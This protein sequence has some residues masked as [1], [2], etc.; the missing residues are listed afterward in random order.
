MINEGLAD[1]IVFGSKN[2]QNPA[3]TIFLHS[4]LTELINKLRTT[5]SASDASAILNYYKVVFQEIDTQGI[6]ENFLAAC[7]NSIAEWDHPKQKAWDERAQ[8]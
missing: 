8:P 4:Q 3:T 7:D 2:I 6:L 5:V 1:E